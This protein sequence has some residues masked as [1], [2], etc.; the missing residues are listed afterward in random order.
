MIFICTQLHYM[1][2]CL[3]QWLTKSPTEI[4]KLDFIQVSDPG[5]LNEVFHPNWSDT[6]DHV[7]TSVTFTQE[8]HLQEGSPVSFQNS[9]WSSVIIL[10][11]TRDSRKHNLWKCFFFKNDDEYTLYV[12]HL[13]SF[14]ENK[15]YCYQDYKNTPSY[16]LKRIYR[17]INSS[18]R[19]C[20]C[21][22]VLK[23]FNQLVS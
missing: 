23:S 11:D 21:F 15:F 18:F 20:F 14:K 19:I 12:A 2:Y 16:C 10:T 13:N 8:N 9:G 5:H 4:R 7:E 22:I 3:E 1:T 6:W 17:N